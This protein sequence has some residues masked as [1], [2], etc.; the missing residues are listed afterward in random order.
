MSYISNT[1]TLKSTYFAYFHSITK[2]GII[3]FWDNSRNSRKIFTLQKKI[4]RIMDTVKPRNSCRSL[5]K[6][7][8][9]LTLPRKYTCSLMNFIVNKQEHFQTTSV[10]HGVTLEIGMTFID[11]LPTFHGFRNVNYYSG[12]NIFNNLPCSLNSLIN[13]KV[14]CTAAL[15]IYLNTCTFYF[16]DE[17]LTFKNESQFLFPY[18]VGM[19]WNGINSIICLVYLIDLL[20]NN[21]IPC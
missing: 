6:R 2:D 8:D 1:D 9:I 18:T 4:I 20:V 21:L 5:F 10:S 16:V 15:K 19:K 7:S 11:Q 13:K 17:F 12:T 14:Q 3:F